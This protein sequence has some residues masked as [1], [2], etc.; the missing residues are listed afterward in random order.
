MERLK[1]IAVIFLL[2]SG[3]ISPA[4][5]AES[6]SSMLQQGLY[7]EETEG[8][9]D[10]AMEI[11]QKIITR[12]DVYERVAAKARYQLGICY[13]KK[14]DHTKAARMFQEVITD[15][16]KQRVIAARARKQLKNVGP[17]QQQPRLPWEVMS[18]IV[19]VH[20]EAYKKAGAMGLRINTHIYGVDDEFNKY[21]GGFLT[22]KNETG[23][24]INEEI[25]LGNFSDSQEMELVNENGMV[26][27]YRLVK[28]NTT[29]IGKYR[30]FWTPDR[31]I[32]PGEVRLLG[33]L[34]PETQKLPETDGGYHLRMN[35]HF[36]SPV[37]ENFFLVAPYNIQITEQSSN[38][39]SRK[40]LGIFEIFLWQK[41]VPANTSNTVNVVLAKKTAEPIV[42]G[43]TPAT[44]TNDV[45][46]SLDKLSVTFDQTMKNGGW[47]WCRW[48]EPY[49]DTTGKPSYDSQFKTCTLPVK[50][51]PGQAYLV[52]FNTKPYI[53]FR[54]ASGVPAK[55]YVLVFA[56]K[57][58]NGKPTPIPQRMLDKADRVNS[59]LVE[60]S[61]VQQ[62]FNDIQPDG[63][64][65]FTNTIREKNRSAG[66]IS[67]KSFINSDFV[68]VTAMYDDKGRP[69]EFT[70]THSGNIYR[71]NAT[72]NEP[73]LPGQTI[74]YS[75]EGTMTGLINPVPGKEQQFRY[76]MAHSPNADVPTQR[77][78]TYLLPAGAELISTNPLTMQRSEKNGRIQLH[79]EKLITPGG[80]IVTGFQYRLGDGNTEFDGD[81]QKLLDSAQ[82]G[83]TVIV[84]AGVYT[85][86][87]K[88]NKP[89]T[90]KGRSRTGC[91]FEVTANKPA[92][93]IDTRGKGK[94]SIEDITI[95]WQLATSDKGI[96]YPF[97]VA[98]K[99]SNAD[100]KGCLFLPLGNPQRSPVAIRA[101]GFSDLA[102]NTC[103]FEG[104]E[105]VVCYGEGTKG[106]MQDSLIM[107]C[108]HQ[109]IILYSGATAR[110]VGNVITGSKYHAVRS[111]GGNLSMRD[112]LIIK[113][114]NRGVY[115]G[116]KSG[117]GI[118][119]NNIIMDNATGISGFASFKA[120]IENNLILNSSYAGISMQQSCSL[121]IRDNIFQANERGWIMFEKG[122][123]GGNTCYRN[124]FWKNKID[125]ENFSKTGNSILEDPR[126]V[127]VGDGDFSLQAGPAKEN[128]QG[129]TNPEV[130]KKLWKR[131][132][133]RKDR[134][135]LFSDQAAYLEEPVKTV[136]KKN[137]LQ[138][139]ELT[140]QGW[141]L[142][143]QRKLTE[144]EEKFKEAVAKDPTNDNAYQGLGWAQLNQGKKFNAKDS[145]E[146]CVRLNPKNSAALN[147]LGWIAH[148]AGNIDE[149]IEWWEK[150]IKV[151]NGRATA[152]L[153]GLTKVY[154]EKG[155]YKNA[156][157][158]YKMWLKAEPNNKQAKKG[159]ETAKASNKN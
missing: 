72:F 45:S 10:K 114:K 28:R 55:P 69:I 159:L 92:I 106:I 16:P 100:V 3:L 119:S 58:E 121:S 102:I 104:F 93:F 15:F 37:L 44:G 140:A 35:N 156:I 60:P 27:K 53:G 103:R 125:A 107:N 118:I 4:V 80:N 5:R 132:Q 79:V 133:N 83:D 31:P 131:W 115:L 99:D 154:M 2:A 151:S 46:P 138:A 128:K 74:V 8:D 76:F 39:I 41:E 116:N 88:I 75:H 23:Q 147:G 33:Y 36:G 141:K 1:S 109:G 12:T 43:T 113:N 122:G 52:A 61:Y 86:P 120:K 85:E 101:I 149:A 81:L 14:G 17:Q 148:G 13:M 143:G 21:F 123:K 6:V 67:T 96:E 129:L 49:P 48:G 84:P 157:K 139:E 24:V 42:V 152:S 65:K 63:T 155:D 146:K 50:L 30:L 97:A 54:S 98:V 47:A 7:A 134:N 38:Y 89:L 25:G 32:Q 26:Q 68:N 142:W 91:V 70:S 71:Y 56:T 135:E 51:K 145:F 11:Y 64:I 105:Y 90:L 94:A 20:M 150:A 124:T 62:T 136:D 87:V 137:K 57:D 29:S 9:L 153:S 40:K 111:T 82:P 66:T 110:V 108:G 158:Y 77:I 126:F 34:K 19:D 117:R 78:E 18:Y 130:F 95:K 144:A 127:S 73:V 112:N 59:L 22:F